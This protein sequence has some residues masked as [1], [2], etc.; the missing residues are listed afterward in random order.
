MNINNNVKG[1]LLALLSYAAYTCMDGSVK[2]LTNSHTLTWQVLIFYLSLVVLIFLFALALYKRLPLKP[3]KPKWLL[4]RAMVGVASLHV[5][6]FILPHVELTLF[7][8]LVFVAPII[9]SILAAIFLKEHINIHRFIS[10][11]VGFI[12]ILIITRPW[13]YFLNTTH[14]Y[15]F[16]DVV[17]LLVAVGDSVIGITVRK[18]LSKDSP[19]VLVFYQ[20]ILC[21]IVSGTFAFFSNGHCI[22]LLP[23]ATMKAIIVT[24]LFTLVGY[25]TYS[26]AV[27][28]APIQVV[29]PM[30]YSQMVFGTILSIFVFHEYP[31]LHT[32]MGTVVIVFATLYLLFYAGSHKKV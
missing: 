24:A 25:V 3:K 19:V 7:Y 15:S 17:P 27:Q 21:S 26:R 12:G 6:F 11:F 28:V 30:G 18:H 23:F 8:S 16:Y 29:M 31:A 9:A 5:I 32:I 20:F 10:I 22:P 1:I 14:N 4:F 13:Q 2:Y